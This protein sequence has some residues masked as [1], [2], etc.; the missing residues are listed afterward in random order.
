MSDWQSMDNAPRDGTIMR[1]KIKELD[2]P[3]NGSWRYHDDAFY[4]C[5]DRIVDHHWQV[6]PVGWA[7]IELEEQDG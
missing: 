1:L 2:Q 7:P 5:A 6:H 4:W 3:V